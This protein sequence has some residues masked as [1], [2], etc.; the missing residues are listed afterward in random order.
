MP[1]L[2]NVVIRRMREAFPDFGLPGAMTAQGSGVG[3][4][5]ELQIDSDGFAQRRDLRCL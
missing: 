2:V 1:E 5:W 4:L 3:D